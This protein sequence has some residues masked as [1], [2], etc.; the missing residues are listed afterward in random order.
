MNYSMTELTEAKRQIDSILQ[1]L[2]E[3]V[4]TLEAK[5][6]LSDTNRR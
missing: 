6:S 5:D 2:N 3:T 4:R 1:K